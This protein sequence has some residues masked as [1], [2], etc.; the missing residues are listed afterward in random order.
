MDKT[1]KPGV[2]FQPAAYHGMQQGINQI[3]NT[4]RPT[5]GPYPRRVVYEVGAGNL[6]FLDD[7]GIIA[8][9][10]IEIAGRNQD[11]GAMFIRHMLWRLHQKVGDGTAT[12]AVLFQTIY[13]EG[14]RH[15]AA[16]VNAP[17]LRRHLEQ[18]MQL[19]LKEIDEMVIPVQGKTKLAQMANSICYEPALAKLLGEIF[20]IIGEYGR[21]DIRSSRS[22]GLDR[23]YVEGMYWK[24]KLISREMINNQARVRAELEDAAILISDIEVENPR[25]LVPV[26]GAAIQRKAK[27][28]FLIANKLSD[29]ALSVLLSKQ[30]R[31]KIKVVAAKLDAFRPVDFAAAHEDLAVLT[32]GQPLVKAAGQ[33]LAEVKPE[34]LGRARRVWADR[35]H[36]GLSG[37]R[38]DPRRLRQHITELREA[39]SQTDDAEIR[40]KLQE[41]IG[42]LLGGSAT[43]WVGGAT[44]SDIDFRKT[45][46]K[47]TAQAIRGAVMEGVVPGGGMALL[48]CKPALQA[49][50]AENAEPEA[51]AAYSILLQALEAP[52]RAL[53]TNAGYEA[54]EIMAKVNRAGPG[55][56][57][58]LETGQIVDMT[59]AG[60]FDVATVQKEAVHSA[61]ASAALAL[62]IDVLVHH[63]K[64][65]QSIEP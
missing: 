50:L 8:R 7:G 29:G 16:G 36:F 31:E 47:R 39:H 41:R 12:A 23:E 52:I 14:L 38:G 25:D 56:G 28:L 5:L 17:Q 33:T 32:G 4:I 3:L 63:K 40:D 44:K 45:L 20:D 15:I 59:Q 26:V 1:Y 18:G 11:M 6:E 46:A 55:H 30:V 61:V 22:R 51:R 64:P 48:A 13:N 62:T 49:R 54:S 10:I 27:T 43:L 9:R 35:Y 42:K 21:L 60:I 58:D 2:V 19:I 65:E 37:G 24:G 53:L 34:H 57:F